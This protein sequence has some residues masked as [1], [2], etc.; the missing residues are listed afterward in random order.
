MGE[1][2]R[3]PLLA[4]M[5]PV[6]PPTATAPEN[7]HTVAPVIA[8]APMTASPSP[9]AE[10]QQI[11]KLEAQLAQ[12]QQE[13]ASLKEQAQQQ[14]YQQGYQ[15]GLRQ[16]E[17][18]AT[19]AQAAQQQQ[20]REQLQ[21][22][23]EQWQQLTQ[24]LRGEAAK[25]QQ[26]YQQALPILFNAALARLVGQRWQDAAFRQACIAHAL[27][28]FAVSAPI[29]VHLHPDTLALLADSERDWGADVQLVADSQ[30]RADG[31]V[32]HSD[33]GELSVSL[34]Q[35]LAQL[36]SSLELL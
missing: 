18:A 15:Q 28:Q 30:V 31:C 6:A 22:Q 27:E 29:R 26:Y 1:I 8:A 34:A 17:Q 16:A 10:A 7:R 25:A 21:Q 14:G 35:Q 13:L 33:S 3:R 20:C 9:S 11:R 5:P 32:L 2:L 24:A 4:T 36:R 23:A 12:L 19:Q